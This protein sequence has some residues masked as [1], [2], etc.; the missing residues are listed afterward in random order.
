MEGKDPVLLEEK[1][2]LKSLFKRDPETQTE[3]E[4]GSLQ[5]A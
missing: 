5:G 1:T 3:G 2:F 4:A